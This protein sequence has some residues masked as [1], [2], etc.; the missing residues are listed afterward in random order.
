MKECNQDITDVAFNILAYLARHPAAKDAIE[1]IVEWWL[2]EQHI[3]NQTAIVRAALE[4]L[5]R[6]GWLLAQD[7]A[8]R[9]PMYSINPEKIEE[10]RQLVSEVP[11]PGGSVQ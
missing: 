7:K 8:G 5:V 11:Y 2:L 3:V 4:T 1:G 6:K 10:V 9:N